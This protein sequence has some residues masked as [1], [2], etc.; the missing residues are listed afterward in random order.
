MIDRSTIIDPFFKA[1]YDRIVPEIDNR[2]VVLASGG[3]QRFSS[4]SRET[5]AEAY[6]R[7]VGYIAALEAMVG[8]CAQIEHEAH[9]N[10][11][12][13]TPKENT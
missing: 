9:G 11:A 12:E 5:T 2:M 3:A 10:R 7:E 4:E 6:A 8:V 13:L 1:L